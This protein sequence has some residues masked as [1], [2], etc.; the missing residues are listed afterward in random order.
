MFAHLAAAVGTRFWSLPLATALIGTPDLRAQSGC[1]FGSHWPGL[2]KCVLSVSRR[3]SRQHAL[4]QHKTS[5]MATPARQQQQR[6]NR[7]RGPP[8]PRKS[9]GNGADGR[10][11]RL[12]PQKGQL[13]DVARA[14]PSSASTAGQ[15][16]VG[17]LGRDSPARLTKPG[18]A[19]PWRTG[20]RL[21]EGGSRTR[22]AGNFG[23]VRRA[24]AQSGHANPRELTFASE[25]DHP[26]RRIH[27]KLDRFARRP[28]HRSEPGKQAGLRNGVW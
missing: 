10:L 6:R 21:R 22:L 25:M 11:Q 13:F 2:R 12:G 24:S 18:R 1:C 5:M 20:S 19:Q 3:G 8:L 15:E 17:R 23:P 16:V 26:A 14:P 28:R 7:C 9:T 4:S 27:F